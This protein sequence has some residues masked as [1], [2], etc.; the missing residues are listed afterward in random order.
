M[1]FSV[2]CGDVALNIVLA[3]QLGYIGPAIATV[4]ATYI[5]VGMLLTIIVTELRVDLAD[6]VPFRHLF[7][8][9]TTAGLSGLAAYSLTLGLTEHMETIVISFIIFVAL[10]FFLGSKAGLIRYSDF[11]ELAGGGAVGKKPEG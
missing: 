10:Y 9:A 2:A 1:R 5:H 4:I 11:I 3:L 8:V 6:I 7:T